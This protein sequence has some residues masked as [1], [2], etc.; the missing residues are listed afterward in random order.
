L[1]AVLVPTIERFVVFGLALTA[2]R[3]WKVALPD[4]AVL[5]LA[6]GEVTSRRRERWSSIARKPD[7][8]PLG[9]D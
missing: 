2:N 7:E 4:L 1:I 5:L 9:R 3:R 8:P 6:I